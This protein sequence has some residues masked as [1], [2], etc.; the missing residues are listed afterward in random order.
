M[1]GGGE[2]L[3]FGVGGGGLPAGQQRAGGD[4]RVGRPGAVRWFG[5]KVP[6]IF[7]SEAIGVGIAGQQVVGYVGGQT[8]CAT[9]AAGFLQGESQI[10]EVARVVAV[11]GADD[12]RDQIARTNGEVLDGGHDDRAA[13]LGRAGGQLLAGAAPAPFDGP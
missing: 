8:P 7:I 13:A 3:A 1:Q 4:D 12:Q 11:A 2:W 9:G 10:C 6:D 5:V